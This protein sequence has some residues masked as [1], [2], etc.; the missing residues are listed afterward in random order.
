LAKFYPQVW[1]RVQKLVLFNSRAPRPGER[2]GID[3]HFRQRNQVEALRS[4]GHHAVLEV[5]G[6][7]QAVDIE[8]LTALLDRSDAFFEG[9]PFVGRVL[10]THPEGCNK[11]IASV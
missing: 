6:D 11:S 5:R 1:S 3:Y 4:T 7:L 8:A 10:Q 9:N 2:D